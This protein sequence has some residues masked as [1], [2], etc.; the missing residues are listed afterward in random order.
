M[1]DRS[2]LFP[3][4]GLPLIAAHTEREHGTRI[5]TF[6]RD[7]GTRQGQCVRLVDRPGTLSG[8]ILR[9]RRD[10]PALPGHAEIDGD[11]V[12]ALAVAPSV[13][14][15]EE[16]DDSEDLSEALVKLPVVDP[17]PSQHFVKRGRYRSEIENL[18]RC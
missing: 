14:A 5:E 12:R 8:D 16:E 4:G 17:D 1:R 10:L 3:P 11:T 13:P 6:W 9:L 2:N 7:D 15:I 18:L